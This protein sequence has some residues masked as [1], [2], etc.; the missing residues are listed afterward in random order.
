NEYGAILDWPQGFFDEAEEEA[1]LI[2]QAAMEKRQARM[3]RRP[4]RE[5]Q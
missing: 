3:P 2:M 1:T 4:D 5:K